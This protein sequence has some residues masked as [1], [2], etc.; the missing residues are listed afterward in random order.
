M[1]VPVLTYHPAR[2]DG[3]DYAS[4]DH[5]AFFHDLR[6]LHSLG[7]SV[8][9]LEDVVASVKSG[10][11]A[12]SR[13][14]AITFDDG[15][16]FDYFD[17]PHPRWGIQRSMLNIMRDF[18]VQFGPN[19]Q[20]SLHAT[21]FVV[22]SP[23]ARREIDR[24][25]LAA[26]GWYT[27]EWWNPAISSGLMGIAN[28][29]WDHNHPQ[30]RANPGVDAAAGTFVSIDNYAAA[31]AQIRQATDYLSKKTNGRA[32][33]FFAYPYG[34]TNEYLVDTY[35]PG[36]GDRHGMQAAFDASPGMV[37]EGSNVWKL[38]RFV[39]GLHWKERGDL[40]RLLLC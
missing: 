1:A 23:E 21:S 37:G 39:F 25:C 34:E 5:V 16:D 33:P 17:L 2:V 15:T 13:R 7:F 8:V 18:I 29:S 32:T 40:A 11:E 10:C 22:V 26:R 9:R 20:P 28:H 24:T 4:N 3:N 31:D 27:D 12:T 19:A 35:L 6:L 14:V 36:C 30:A 38:P